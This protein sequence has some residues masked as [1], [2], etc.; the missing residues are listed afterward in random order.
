MKTTPHSVRFSCLKGTVSYSHGRNGI[1]TGG[2]RGLFENLT[3][4]DTVSA[5]GS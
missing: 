3:S 4:I 2:F 5:L 1:F